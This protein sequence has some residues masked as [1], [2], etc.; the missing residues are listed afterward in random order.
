M[1]K[2]GK[3]RSDTAV[4]TPDYISP[5][6]LTSQVRKRRCSRN[7]EKNVFEKNLKKPFKRRSAS[8]HI[9]EKMFYKPYKTH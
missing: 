3:I 7:F 2:N 1:D 8:G 6:V 9:L 4:G 5:E